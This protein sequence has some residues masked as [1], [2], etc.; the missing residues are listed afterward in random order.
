MPEEPQTR[1]SLAGDLTR[2]GLRPGDIVLAHSSLRS[3]GWVCGGALAVVQALLDALGPDGTL[4]V[5]TQTTGNSDPMHWRHPPVP[6]SWWP[7]IREHMPAFDPAVTPSIGLGV[8]PE[9]VRT[10][11]GAVRS[12]HP[13]TS[14]AAVGPAAAELMA[15][16]PLD[17]QLGERSPLAALERAGARVLLLGVGFD[18]C[19]AFHLAEYRIPDPP[20]FEYGTAVLTPSGRRWVT[21]TDVVTNSDDFDHLGAAFEQTRPVRHGKVGEAS[22]RLFDVRPAV[23]FAAGWLAEHRRPAAKTRAAP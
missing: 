6:E 4:V 7:V 23:K 3:L 9:L 1:A 13:H 20:L 18:T 15:E 2:L 16:H 8:L 12:N 10:W 19:T 21:Y 5:P 14:F 22:C 11:P 17:C